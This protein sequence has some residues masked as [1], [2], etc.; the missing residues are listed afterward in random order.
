MGQTQLCH[1]NQRNKTVTDTCWPRDVSPL[2]GAMPNCFPQPITSRVNRQDLFV[3]SSPSSSVKCI[4]LKQRLVSSH[5]IQ[6]FISLEA[7]T[8]I[9]S[10]IMNIIQQS[11]YCLFCQRK[12]GFCQILIMNH[13]T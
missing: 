13:I 11:R 12:E 2:Q 10:C 1:F 6:N 4:Q 9:C 8:L 3:S 7:N 5:G